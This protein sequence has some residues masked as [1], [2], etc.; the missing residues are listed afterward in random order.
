MCSE[1]VL[2]KPAVLSVRQM[3]CSLHYAPC[4]ALDGQL[5]WALGAWSIPVEAVMFDISVTSCCLFHKLHSG[6]LL[7]VLQT[8]IGDVILVF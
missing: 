6:M 3:W 1:A 4:P 7:L 2:F 8:L 5:A